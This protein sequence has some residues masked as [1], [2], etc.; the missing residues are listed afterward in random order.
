VSFPKRVRFLEELKTLQRQS[1]P[2]R[3]GELLGSWEDGRLKFWPAEILADK[4]C[5]EF[6]ESPLRTLRERGVHS[7]RNRRAASRV[8]DSCC[9]TSA[10]RTA[11]TNKLERLARG[12]VVIMPADV[13]QAHKQAS[14]GIFLWDIQAYTFRHLPYHADVIWTLILL[15]RSGHQMR[16]H[17]FDS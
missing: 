4:I 7:G 10:F 14:R 16:A 13:P 11:G 3:F 6:Q 1:A 15:A 17:S 9:R 8:L 5:A 12:N 2:N